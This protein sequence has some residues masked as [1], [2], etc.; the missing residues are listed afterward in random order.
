MSDPRGP[1]RTVLDVES[2]PEAHRARLDCGHV[3]NLTR[4]FA[5]PADGA[6]VRC[7]HCREGV[8]KDE[9]TFTVSSAWS[10]KPI[11]VGVSIR[12]ALHHAEPYA[13]ELAEGVELADLDGM[14]IGGVWKT[15]RDSR[16][17]RIQRIA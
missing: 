10:G 6:S 15:H 4:H 5:A 17:I 8:M 14:E 7:F 1:F 2:T 16:G 11:A 9:K 3:A 12:A 13:G